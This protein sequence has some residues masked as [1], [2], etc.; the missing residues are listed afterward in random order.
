MDHL[1][2]LKRQTRLYLCILLFSSGLVV[3]AVW[4]VG[5]SLLNLPS[6]IVLII[7][8][9]ASAGMALAFA[10]AATNYFMGPLTS[11]WQA[12]LHVSPGPS[13][14]AAPNLEKLT[15]GRELVT[16]LALEVYELASGSNKFQTPDKLNQQAKAVMTSLPLPLFVVDKQQNIT[17]TNEMAQKYIGKQVTDVVGK[18]VYSVLDLSFPTDDT[19]DSWLNQSRAHT[20]TATKTWERVRLM[21][22]NGK[23]LLFDLAAYYNKDNPSGVEVILTLFDHS[24]LYGQDE[25]AVGYLALAVHELRSPLTMLRGYIEV[26]EE[27]LDGKLDDELAGFMRKMEVTAQQLT[28]LVNNILNVARVDADQLTLQLTEENWGELVKAVGQELSL[29]AEV[30][31]K[32]IEYDIAPNL[33]TVGAD[34]VSIYEVLSN[35]IDNSIKYSDKSQKILIKSSLTKDGQIETVVQD[36]GVGIPESVIPTL[37]EKFQRNHRNQAKIG[38]TGL[39]LYLSKAIVN[40]HGGNIWIRSKEGQGTT[41]GFTLQPYVMVANKLKSSNNGSEQGMVRNAHGWIKNHS[42]YRR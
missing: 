8:I 34:R 38:G 2:R 4:L 9:L 26:F 36:W 7:V 11:V 35:L 16:S 39:G 21:Q 15:F 6:W 20:V 24:A 41:V 13:S 42:L 31:G 40:A 10:Q 25:Q 18:N 29:R 32:T 28:T 37:F 19:L 17:F 22:D 12:I 14:T 5:T 1:E 23:A 33:P 3:T 27:E 30:H